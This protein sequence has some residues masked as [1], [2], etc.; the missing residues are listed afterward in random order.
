MT[1]TNL[2]IS[3]CL[4]IYGLGIMLFDF[5]IVAITGNATIVFAMSELAGVLSDKA[6]IGSRC[7]SNSGADCTTPGNWPKPNRYF[8]MS[9][10]RTRTTPKV[11]IGWDL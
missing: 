2:T 10:L 4:A 5:D 7:I 1:Y 3:I 8:G 9:W 6:D 11:S